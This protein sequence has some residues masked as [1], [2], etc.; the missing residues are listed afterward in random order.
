MM[1]TNIH[2]KLARWHLRIADPP[3]EV[4]IPFA[5]AVFTA[6]IQISQT[7]SDKNRELSLIEQL[8]TAIA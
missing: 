1:T 4:P 5:Q 2:Y 8:F 6:I 3:V 7:M